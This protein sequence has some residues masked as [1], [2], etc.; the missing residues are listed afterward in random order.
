MIYYYTTWQRCIKNHSQSLVF[1]HYKCFL[2][3]TGNRNRVVK[4]VKRSQSCHTCFDLA[5]S[6][7]PLIAILRPYQ[8][9]VQVFDYRRVSWEGQLPKPSEFIIRAPDHGLTV[10]GVNRGREVVREHI[11]S[12][13]FPPKYLAH[14]KNTKRIIMTE[15]LLKEVAHTIRRIE[16]TNC[17]FFL[18]IF[19]PG[20]NYTQLC[21]TSK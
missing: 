6:C 17:I 7:K 4:K 12:L 11:S 1:Q 10:S 15:E 2:L 21:G 16:I 19:L 20:L 9:S 18:T 8:Y 3:L 5:V 13:T 14:N